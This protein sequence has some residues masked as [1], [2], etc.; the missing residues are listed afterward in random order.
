MFGNISKI[1]SRSDEQNEAMLI[2]S[3]AAMVE[4]NPHVI[5]HNFGGQLNNSGARLY[6]YSDLNGMFEVRFFR[7]KKKLKNFKLE[8]S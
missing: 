2:S 8:F 7:R 4:S 5:D 3:S 1:L 6:N